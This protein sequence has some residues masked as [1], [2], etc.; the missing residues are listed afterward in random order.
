VGKPPTFSVIIAAY[1]AAHLV[2]D[3]VSSALGQTRPPHEVIVCDDGSTDDLEGALAPYRDRVAVIQQ[4]NRGEA[5]AKNTAARASSGD[6]VAILDADDVYLPERL[7]AL[8]ELA[9]ARPDLDI[10]TTDAY[11]ELG[12][13]VLRRCYSGGFRFVTGDQRRGIL[14]DNF[15]FGHVAVRRERLLSAGGFDETLRWSTDWDCWIRL[16]VG[17]SQAGLVDEPLARYRVQTGSLS[18]QRT[19]MLAGRVAT[20]ERAV[21]LDELTHEER[22][23]AERALAGYRR[24]LALA[25]AREALEARSPDA[26]GL[27][28]AVARGPQF[29]ARTRLKAL[30]SAAAPRVA[31]R[32]LAGRPRETTGGVLLPPD[33]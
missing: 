19:R 25:E 9:A 22:E 29:S 3:A 14:E 6:F 18:S 4:E 33:P 32:L 30:A 10:L 20:L 11:L 1:Q 17:G 28:L 12:E 26:R 27:A 23:T 21:A 31:R 8:G 24:R 13:E 2:G 5:G 7:E 16:I 15:I